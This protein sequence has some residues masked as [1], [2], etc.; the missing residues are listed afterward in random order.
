MMP[1]DFTIFEL[2]RKHNVPFLIVGGHAVNFYGYPRATDDVDVVW[3]RS[4]ETE[5]SLLAALE[6]VNG[7]YIGKDIDP[8]TGIE[9]TYA[10]SLPYI[11]SHQLMMLCTSRGFVDLF[12]YIPGFPD[13]N[14]HELFDS[15]V[16]GEN[17]FRYASLQWLRRMKTV[18]G[19]HKDLNDLEELPEE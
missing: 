6:E 19:R 4:P 2:L 11:Q 16:V 7:E 1:T 12:S 9:R 3:L 17:G 15:S 18:T 13:A 5:R 8:T 10:V 14:V